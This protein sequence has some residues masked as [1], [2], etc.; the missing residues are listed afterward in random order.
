MNKEEKDILF[1]DLIRSFTDGLGIPEIENAIIIY[2]SKNIE[3]IYK[4]NI[5]G[6]SDA[7]GLIEIGKE[8]IRNKIT[9]DLKN[10]PQKTTQD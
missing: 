2:K 7:L 9:K 5:N 4:Y 6:H 8:L 3:A 1:K 10:E